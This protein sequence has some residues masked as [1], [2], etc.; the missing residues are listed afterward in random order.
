[1]A[2]DSD[3]LATAGKIALGVGA[4]ALMT[5][6]G[7]FLAKSGAIQSAAARMKRNADRRLVRPPCAGTPILVSLAHGGAEH[8]GVYLGESRVAELSGDGRL[9][10]V[11][12]TD[13]LNG[14]E[15]GW[16]N[17]RAGTR[18]FAAC[19]GEGGMPVG[20]TV[21]SEAANRLIEHVG[22]VRYNLF[23]NNCHMFT[24]SCI[25]GTLLKGMSVVDWFKRGTFSI[26]RLEEI[27]SNTLNGGRPIAWL[28]VEGP[29][30]QFDYALTDEKAMRLVTQGMQT[31][32]NERKL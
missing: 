10:T 1:M 20:S 17:F 30:M 7:V 11:S 23:S 25:L 21:V 6:G 27:I 14:R 28:G 29:T 19:D 13:F 32:N 5:A 3:W 26:D 8:S 2:D 18:I 22:R 31:A 24:A 12:L 4:G 16:D 9:Q 15:R